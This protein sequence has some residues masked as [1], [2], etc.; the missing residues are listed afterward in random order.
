[1]SLPPCP[2]CQSQYVY[3]DQSQ[4]VCPECAHEW[5]PTEVDESVFIAK[6]A[7]GTALEEGDKVTLAKDL[8]VKGSS[9]VLKIGTKAVVRRIVEGKDHELDCKVDGA[10]EMMVT[11]KFVKKA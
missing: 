5:N 4:L 1:M 2:N 8:K 6:D 9:L 11:A 3:Q 10:G 7:N